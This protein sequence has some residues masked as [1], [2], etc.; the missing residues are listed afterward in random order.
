VLF[1]L[2]IGT[3]RDRRRRMLSEV[4]FDEARVA[5]GSLAAAQ[6]PDATIFPIRQPAFGFGLR[7]RRAR[8]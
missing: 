1:E 4:Y 6:A 7:R 8:R 5:S 3:L 2:S